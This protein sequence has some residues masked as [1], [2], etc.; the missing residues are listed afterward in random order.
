MSEFSRILTDLEHT[1]KDTSRQESQDGL[2]KAFNDKKSSDAKLGEFAVGISKLSEKFLHAKNR[3]D[4]AQREQVID[5]KNSKELKKAQDS[6]N[7]K[8]TELEQTGTAEDIQKFLDSESFKNAEKNLD[9][10]LQSDTSEKSRLSISQGFSNKITGVKDRLR[11][12]LQAAIQKENINFIE[13]HKAEM[14]LK[15]S[16]N[17]YYNATSDT[18]DLLDQLKKKGM[19][20]K[21]QSNVVKAIAGDIAFAKART[22]IIRNDKAGMERAL[23]TD[24]SLMNPQQI[25]KLTQ[26]ILNSDKVTLDTTIAQ[27]ENLHQTGDILGVESNLSQITDPKLKKATASLVAIARQQVEKPGINEYWSNAHIARI[28]KDLDLQNPQHVKFVNSLIKNQKK[29]NNAFEKDLDTFYFGAK[30]QSEQTPQSA[31]D[32]QEKRFMLRGSFI[33]KKQGELNH[34]AM[35][36]LESQKDIQNFYYGIG[37]AGDSKYS[38]VR[39]QNQLDYQL[40]RANK[41]R[42]DEV[43]LAIGLDPTGTL[44]ANNALKFTKRNKSENKV[45]WYIP[46]EWSKVRHIQGSEHIINTIK[47]EIAEDMIDYQTTG[48]QSKVTYDSDY[49]EEFRKR[50]DAR[51]EEYVAKFTEPE[52]GEINSFFLGDKHWSMPKNYLQNGSAEETFDNVKKVLNPQAKDIQKRILHVDDFKVLN[53]N[54]GSLKIDDT[55]HAGQW[56]LVLSSDSGVSPARNRQGKPI[57]FGVHELETSK[58]FE[59]DLKE[60]Q[61]FV[62]RIKEEKEVVRAGIEGIPEGELTETEKALK[63]RREAGF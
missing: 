5:I 62:R 51:V 22:H 32:Y 59:M 39:I 31:L 25:N 7:T 36:K 58:L 38:S 20:N 26:S 43:E 48:E 12:S 63:R 11:I 55:D 9:G 8:L 47:Y 56:A 37:E 15:A 24:G 57:I 40:R 27:I 28:S 3:I 29:V 46:E 41:T 2:I 35:K 23:K 42:R 18:N 50:L 53:E 45:T 60:L 34:S 21:Q 33:S 1:E 30:P 4:L 17:P 6:I 10:K 49:D 16:Q 61:D 19:N 14:V 44:R 52:P 13:S 54:R